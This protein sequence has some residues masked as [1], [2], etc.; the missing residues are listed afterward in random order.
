MLSFILVKFAVAEAF[1]NLHK[2]DYNSF[3]VVEQQP[4]S[5]DS[6]YASALQTL[7]EEVMILDCFAHIIGVVM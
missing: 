3:H 4:N 1:V 2:S 7:D 6:M 5:V